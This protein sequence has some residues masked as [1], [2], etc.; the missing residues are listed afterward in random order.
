MS[1]AEWVAGLLLISGSVL[2]VVAGVGIV[3]FPHFYTRLHAAGVIDTLAAGLF[4]AGIGVLFGASLGTVKLLLVFVFLLFTSPT[5]CHALARS[6]WLAGLREPAA[7]IESAED[8]KS[9][10]EPR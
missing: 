5:A 9:A 6:A 10:G 2:L 8:G 7:P 4:L 1:L 3:R